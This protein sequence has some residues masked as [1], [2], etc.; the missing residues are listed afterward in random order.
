MSLRPSHQTCY[1]LKDVTLRIGISNSLGPSLENCYSWITLPAE[2]T[3]LPQFQ[4]LG[5]VL[6]LVISWIT[7]PAE[8]TF[9]SNYLRP[10]LDMKKSS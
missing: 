7:L 8:L 5:Q 9:L 6:K 3:F 2:Q 10:D 1:I 4:F